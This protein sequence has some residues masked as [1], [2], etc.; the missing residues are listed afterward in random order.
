MIGKPCWG[1]VRSEVLTQQPAKF[2]PPPAP[3]LAQALAINTNAFKPVR[4]GGAG[5]LNINILGFRG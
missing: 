4:K 5:R 2:K 1:G 3:P